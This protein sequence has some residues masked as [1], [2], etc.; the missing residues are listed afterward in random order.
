M[1]DTAP[2]TAPTDMGAWR[3]V[4]SGMRERRSERAAGVITEA[5]QRYSSSYIMFSIQH[6][7]VSKL[8]RPTALIVRI[9]RL[10]MAACISSIGV[11]FVMVIKD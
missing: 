11:M 5:S 7:G 1:L 6:R 10:I 9:D 2:G 4:C 8:A 3:E